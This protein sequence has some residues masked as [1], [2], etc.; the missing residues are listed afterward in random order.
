[1][2]AAMVVLPVFLQAPWVRLHPFSAVL[3]TVIFL[4]IGLTL[5][6]TGVGRRADIGSLL[7]GFRALVVFSPPRQSSIAPYASPAHIT[8]L[9]TSYPF[10]VI[11]NTLWNFII[12]LK[13]VLIYLF[14]SLSFLVQSSPIWARRK[15][16]LFEEVV[17]LSHH[18]LSCS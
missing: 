2:A 5:H 10:G 6:L 7:V 11:L 17:C 15:G 9:T 14:F 13:Y 4:A 18:S 1:M 16:D 3:F 12:S 8:R